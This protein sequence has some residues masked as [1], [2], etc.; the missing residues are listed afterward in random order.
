MENSDS[1][2]YI[3]EMLEKNFPSLISPVPIQ[4]STSDFSSTESLPMPAPSQ[5]KSAKEPSNHGQMESVPQ[6]FKAEREQVLA[7]VGQMRLAQDLGA[8]LKT[9]VTEVRNRLQADRVLIYRFDTES[10][11]VVTSETV[12]RGWAPAIGQ[13]LAAAS[14]GAEQAIEYL[15]Q[16]FVAIADVQTAELSPYQI[17][18][19]ER[20]QV[21]SSVSLPILT[22][23]QIWG[24][25]VVQQCV[26]PRHWQEVEINLL[27]Q[28]TTQLT[29]GLQRFEFDLQQRRA[30]QVERVSARVIDKIREPQAVAAIFQT[31][32]QELRR[33]L[34]CDRV[35][36]YRFNNE[37]GGEFVAESAGADWV[38]LVGPDI[39]T[40]WED[41]HLQETQ[42]GRYA[43]GETFAVDDIYKVGHSD[44]HIEVLEQFQVKAYVVV[45]I[46]ARE[47][48]WGLLAAYQNSG[49][50]V[51][52]DLEKSVLKQIC[53]SLW[54]ALQ[55][56]EDIQQIRDQAEQLQR[57][58]ELDEAVAKVTA[59]IRQTPDI[60]AIF[61]I[62][63]RELR[64]LLKADRVGI[65]RF[66]PD[67]SGEFVVESVGA[68]WT[69]VVQAQAQND[70]LLLD[71]TTS[72]RCTL[73]D[74]TLSRPDT[75][76]YLQGTRGGAYRR[77]QPFKQVDDVY[78]MGFDPCYIRRLEMYQARAYLILPI[79]QGNQ[80]WGLL[81][82][83]HN[84]GPHPWQYWEINLMR[85]IAP[86]LGLAIQQSE[87]IKAAEREQAVTKI[88]DKIRRPLDVNAIFKTATQDVRNLLVAERVALYRFNS[89]WSGEFVAESVASNWTALMQEQIDNPILKE[90][91]SE[92]SVKL[93][94]DKMAQWTD[95]HIQ[96]TQGG[97]YRR[98]GV[99]R[100]ANDIYSEDFPPCYIE[101]LERY[102]AKAYI[103][104]AIAQGE[105][106][107]GLL[108]VYQNSGAR[109]WTEGEV[110]VTVQIG[111]QLGLALQQAEYL[112]QVQAKSEQLAK[113]AQRERTVAKVIEK[114]RRSPQEVDSIFETTT[115][116]IRKLL[117][118][119]RVTIYKFRADYFGDF[120]VESGLGDW[121]P[122]VGSGWEDSYLNEHQGGR[123]RNNEPLV[124][125][126]VYNGGLTECHVEALEYFGVKSCAVVAITQGQKLWG[127]LSAFQHSGPRHWDE[128]EV[129]LLSQVGTQLG[130]A[131]QQEEYVVQV[132]AKSDQLAKTAQQERAV[133]NVID[134]IRK[135]LD[136]DTIFK[137]TTQEVRKLLGV[138]RL[139]IYKFRPDYFGDFLVESESGDWPAL[140][141]SG[142]EDP[143]LNE[144]QGGRFRNNEPL[145]VEDVYN[146]GLSE[147]HVEALEYFGVKAC[148]VVAIFQGQKLWGLLSAFQNSGPRHW[149]ENEI[150][151]MSQVGT[152]LGVALQQAEYLAQ[153]QAKSEQLAKVAERERAAG[154]VV[155]KIR[156]TL[157]IN[158]IFRNTTQ[159]V[160]QLLAV[161]RLSIY[162]F[163]P[164]YFG[165]FVAESE[166]PGW[167]KLV[168]PERL[169]AWEDPYLQEHQGGRFRNNEALVVDD[170][171]HAGMTPCH[172]EALERFQVKACL[173]VPILQG[174]KLWGLLSAFQN[175]GPRH[176]DESDVN[177]LKQ[178]GAQLGV[179]LQQA[180]YL[181][182]VQAQA[183]QLAE[184]ASREK[185][186]KEQL[187][188][189]AVQLLAAVRPVLR[190][191]LT[192]RAPVT[193]DEVGTIADAYN[194]T[195][196]SLRKIVMQ[197]QT[198][199][200][201][202]AQTSRSSEASISELSSQAQ[203]QFRELSLTL[204]QI[205]TMSHST[206]VVAADARQVE[207]AVQQ[208]N[209]TVKAGDA[210]MNRTVDGIL[211]I[212]ETVAETSQKIKRL[213]ESSQKISRVVNLIGNF[214]S[215]T[216]LL[217]LNASIE[218]TRAGEYGRGFAVVAD[219]VR[220]LAR[221]SAAATS[222]IEK[223]VQE[224]Q[225]ETG[226]VAAAMET[227]IQRVVEG[228]NL[229]NETRTSL[230][231]VVEAT[232]QISHLVEGITQATQVQTQQS[233][234][235]TQTMSTV[236]TIANK[237]SE[238]SVQ[239]AASFKS[240]LVMAEG[241]L[242]SVGQFKVDPDAQG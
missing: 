241:L 107:W 141:G 121:P 182:Q 72:D 80:L 22:G 235:V 55:Q 54:I 171:Y 94:G 138:E 17:Q 88:V 110:N 236:A 43:R 174:Q 179:A 175:T 32:T 27:Y 82:A 217:A 3:E 59:R 206:Q 156:K 230:N 28:V 58:V 187:Q 124:V 204:A 183:Q 189:R 122:L 105:K 47:K 195:I 242:A 7:I 116:E 190:G 23:D 143:Y 146:G 67:W 1:S 185:A 220:S 25:L 35:A 61:Q 21:R 197:V 211:E 103:I 57:S 38:P 36:V 30:L 102:Q 91:I 48:L 118:V 39:K 117:G 19:L 239:L 167:P 4:E 86:Q 123:F 144:H 169:T 150:R 142:W 31:A 222:E 46:F 63:T 109:Q 37:W 114:I 181:G 219:E 224:I 2:Q 104:V 15:E 161:E 76:T 62:V 66:N 210:A 33:L 51:W 115:Q 199:T 221:Q 97:F 85:Q 29:I 172:V 126:D 120:V 177:L 205:Q 26:A 168:G 214:T 231:A 137:T 101:M 148:L 153:V 24:L 134:K 240:L 192:V 130:V 108:A 92:C 90:N 228:T 83:Y 225:L 129:K 159:E 162:K 128:D 70:Y 52:T 145:V 191:D 173:V 44:C 95:T 68:D 10:Q 5:I 112:E 100:V 158:T 8:L 99:F 223:L 106:L 9:T 184:A 180:E 166:A 98:G 201:R 229:V 155:D 50:R 170:I 111:T 232:S 216:Q 226:A 12:G 49:P 238:D 78:A 186:A 13:I 207:A 65:Y 69:A 157:D 6:A 165:D 208:A 176:W 40:I 237:T 74:L 84:S 45:P 18:L 152:Q 119:E 11:G 193:E 16:L 209:Q 56:A 73:K 71:T 75:D 77:G 188:G 81:A 96:R 132:Q 203:A 93:L 198:A 53:G 139:T 233:Q 14:F 125:D 154:A 131:L 227:G 215:Q 135:T 164:D 212:R 163:R 34:T 87:L 194:N 213:S 202:V 234:S 127:L 41:T 160:R 147:C 89:D 79:F 140:V 60:G 136:I 133:A 113:V 64:Q 20:L 200:T 178:I 218:A 149:E 196:Q 151:L 42:G